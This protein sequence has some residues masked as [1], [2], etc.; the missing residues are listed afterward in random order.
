M[1][2]SGF[3]SVGP[4]PADGL[5]STLH[6]AA[7]SAMLDKQEKTIDLIAAMKVAVPFEVEL[8][9]QPTPAL[10]TG[11]VFTNLATFVLA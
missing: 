5:G 6:L 2:H 3:G 1:R 8:C 7:D 11:A 9:R 4:F 10:R